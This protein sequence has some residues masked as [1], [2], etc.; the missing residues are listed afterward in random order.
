MLTK[1]LSIVMFSASVITSAWYFSKPNMP[2]NIESES[3]KLIDKILKENLGKSFESKSVDEIY[4]AGP[5]KTY[6]CKT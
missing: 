4:I 1:L 3:Q 6:L 2:G 5:N